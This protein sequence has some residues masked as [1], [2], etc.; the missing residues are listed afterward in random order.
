MA[1]SLMATVWGLRVHQVQPQCGPGRRC[2]PGLDPLNFEAW[3]ELW[4]GTLFAMVTSGKPV[5]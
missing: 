3:V 2:W 5:A 1:T 4:I